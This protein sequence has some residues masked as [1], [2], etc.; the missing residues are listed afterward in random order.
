MQ[1]QRFVSIGAMVA[2]LA[3]ACLLPATSHAAG[4]LRVEAAWIRSAPPGVPM[5]AGYA[6]LR[7]SGDAALVIERTSSTQ[8]GA[9]SIHATINEDGVARMRE[10]PPIRLA[11]GESVVLEPGGKHLMLMQPNAELAA[12]AK[13]VLHFE[14]DNGSSTDAEFVVRDAPATAGDHAHHH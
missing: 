13:A 11:P 14:M 4:V 12:G 5:R 9:V 7:N 3:V 2:G 6:T 10:L 8:F 1:G